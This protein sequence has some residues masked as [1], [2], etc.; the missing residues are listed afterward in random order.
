[1]T[2]D[3]WNGMWRICG[4]CEISFIQTEHKK[5][6]VQKFCSRKCSAVYARE[7]KG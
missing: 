7:D 6:R 2:K 4:T 5:T 3:D 1:M